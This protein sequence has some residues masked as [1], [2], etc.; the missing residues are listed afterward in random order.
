MNRCQDC[1]EQLISKKAK[2]CRK[3]FQLE[4]RNN[5][6]VGDKV[7]IGGVHDWAKKRLFK[8]KFCQQCNKKTRFLDL[9]NISQKYKRDLLDWKWL[10]RSCHM[11]EDGR[12][13]NLHKNNR[14]GFNSKEYQ[15]QW[16]LKNKRKCENCKELISYDAM[17][18]RRCSN[19]FI[20]RGI[21][22]RGFIN[23]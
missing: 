9:T 8:P 11:K 3:C 2:Y 4:K 6:W 19:I 17:F 13:I 7:G 18:C 15:T 10:C 1:Y 22:I 16:K 23:Q 21:A 14:T 5:Q 20:P 12:L